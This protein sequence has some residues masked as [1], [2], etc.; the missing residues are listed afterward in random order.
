M[1][2]LWDTKEHHFRQGYKISQCIMDNNMGEHGG[3]SAPDL[4]DFGMAT[5]MNR[6]LSAQETAHV[7]EIP[8]S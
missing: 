8:A 1:G 2:T 5:V 4:Y 6:Q 3:Q 7:E